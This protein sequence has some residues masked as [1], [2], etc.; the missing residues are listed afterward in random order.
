MRA[1]LLEQF[2]P[3]EN[4]VLREVP[5]PIRGPGEVLISVAA[6]GITF[7]ETVVRAGRGWSAAQRPALPFIPG[8]GVAGTTDGRRVV[9]TTGGS[10]GYAELVAVSAAEPLPV[11]EGLELTEAVA[12]LADGRTAVGLARA[13][14]PQPGEWVLVEAAGGGVG[15]LLV[16]LA[17]RAG[18]RVIAAAGGPRKLELAASL[19]AEATVDYTAPGW[20]DRVRAVTG[21]RGPDAVFDSVGGDIGRSALELVRDGGRFCVMGAASGSMTVPPDG[22]AA[23]RGLRMTGLGDVLPTPEAVRDAAATALAEAAA[24]RLHPTIGQTFPLSRAAEAHAAIEA[25]ATVGKTLLLP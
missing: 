23:R 1:V 16:Q 15:S 17:T 18:S 12:L 21:G 22:E 25:R 11:P 14:R 4:L 13:V 2:G 19:G 9:S 3:P 6:A 10:G 24:G 8:N 5:D 20:E 7:I